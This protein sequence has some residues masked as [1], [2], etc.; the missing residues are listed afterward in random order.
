MGIFFFSYYSTLILYI[1]T[2]LDSETRWKYFN[3]KNYLE[4]SRKSKTEIFRLHSA[5][6]STFSITI[7]PKLKRISTFALSRTWIMHLIWWSGS[8]AHSLAK[9]SFQFSYSLRKNYITFNF[10]EYLT[11]N[12]LSADIYHHRRMHSYAPRLLMRLRCQSQPRTSH[13]MREKQLRVLIL[14]TWTP[15]TQKYV[16]SVDVCIWLNWFRV[17]VF[18]C[19][20]WALNVVWM[21]AEFVVSSCCDG[22][23]TAN[24]SLGFSFARAH[25]IP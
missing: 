9:F 3:K 16:Y 4:F 14:S 21:L 19:G 25:K 8:R 7:F 15:T 24:K 6:F 23:R 11:Y 5:V 22:S 17:A 10:T 18:G 1:S 20:G 13:R 12:A 2:R